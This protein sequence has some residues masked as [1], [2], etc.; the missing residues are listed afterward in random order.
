MGL[1][2]SAKIKV[3]EF[4]ADEAGLNHKQKKKFDRLCRELQIHEEDITKFYSVWR[5]IEP[6]GNNLVSEHDYVTKLHVEETPFLKRALTIKDDLGH[7]DPTVKNIDFIHFFLK[8][9]QVCALTETGLNCFAF[10][11]YDVD[12]G[13][14]IDVK[15]LQQLAKEMYGDDYEHDHRLTSTFSKILKDHPNTVT[16]KQFES[17]IFH[18]PLLTFPAH[19]AQKDLQRH[20]GGVSW[21]KHLT[22]RR[23]LGHEQGALYALKHVWEKFEEA[24]EG[25]AEDVGGHHHHHH[26]HH[27]GEAHGKYV[28]HHKESKHHSHHKKKHTAADEAHRSSGGL[29]FH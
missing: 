7:N 12:G 8:T 23:L 5:K 17:V 18:Y 22:E 19:Q 25:V 14:V 28:T 11:L 20:T 2:G 3:Y 16:L 26:H 21:W 13:G 24:G 15:E 6:T 4:D 1:C 10:E 9:Y 27:S 29:T